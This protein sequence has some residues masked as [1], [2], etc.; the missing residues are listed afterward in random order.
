MGRSFQFDLIRIASGL[1]LVYFLVLFS[2]FEIND[3]SLSQIIIVLFIL[4]IIWSALALKFENRETGI[5]S[6]NDSS[7]D[8]NKRKFLLYSA[9][10]IISIFAVTIVPDIEIYSGNLLYNGNFKLGTE[11]WDLPEPN[12]FSWSIDDQNTFD[13]LPSLE[14]QTN[15][16]F[17][18]E[19]LW[20]WISSRLI[21]VESGSKYEIITHM[22]GKNV[23]QSSV[24]IQPYDAD[25]KPLNYQLA[26]VPYGQNGTFPFTEYK[27]IVI[28]PYGVEYIGLYLLGGLAY[29]SGSP[30]KTYFAKLSVKKVSQLIG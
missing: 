19:L 29:N 4:Y 27:D 28:I 16:T 13:G 24:V 7:V 14:V 12:I 10:A 8:V 9:I 3:I 17:S 26:Q 30:G 22:A 2:I 11:G 20:S 18:Y 6:A 21:N 25:R 5:V 15:N 23:L 1:L